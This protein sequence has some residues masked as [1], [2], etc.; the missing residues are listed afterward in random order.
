MRVCKVAL[1]KSV[2][3]PKFI[4]VFFLVW[5]GK[6]GSWTETELSLAGLGLVLHLAE[7]A[8]ADKSCRDLSRSVELSL[9]L[10]TNGR[11][12][13]KSHHCWRLPSLEID[14]IITLTFK[15]SSLQPCIE[16]E[17]LIPTDQVLRIC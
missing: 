5:G 16:E 13:L 11:S 17:H 12:H 8:R 6:A 7:L 15:S 10:P 3:F 1:A 2:Y 9:G 14:E 4:R